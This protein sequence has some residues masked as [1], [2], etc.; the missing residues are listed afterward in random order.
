MNNI[1]AFIGP[2]KTGTT[3]LYEYLKERPDVCVLGG[4]D[5]FDYKNKNGQKKIC[6]IAKSKQI[7]TIFFD[8]DAL[9]S[10]S[11]ML[12][13]SELNCTPIILVRNPYDQ[14]VSRILHDLRV[15]LYD[16]QRVVNC[17]HLDEIDERIY[18]RGDYLKWHMKFPEIM[19]KK[20]VYLDFNF[21]ESNLMV[22]KLEELMNLD[23]QHNN[24]LI[25][26]SNQAKIGKFPKFNYFIRSTLKPLFY[27]FGLDLYWSKFKLSK[28][29]QIFYSNETVDETRKIIEGKVDRSHTNKMFDDFIKS[30]LFN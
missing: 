9:F 3:S 24:Q 15:G 19:Q 20:A 4:K 21:F 26:K 11:S 28:L 10:E 5:F 22:K 23:H 16:L 1:F 6:Q 29:A 12:A 2:C 27:F 25:K 18:D 14:A 17:N 13:L 30:G 8:H 7:S